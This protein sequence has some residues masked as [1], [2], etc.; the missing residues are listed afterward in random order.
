MNFGL[1]HTHFQIDMSSSTV[2]FSAHR[3]HIIFN[4]FKVL[5][6]MLKQLRIT[7]QNC[8]KLSV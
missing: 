5:E 2:F 3:M 6:T 1:T 7:L 4:F 8:E